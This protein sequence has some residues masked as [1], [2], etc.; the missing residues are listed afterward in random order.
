[1]SGEEQAMWRYCQW[2]A[3]ALTATSGRGTLSAEGLPDGMRYQPHTR[4][5]ISIP[6][7]SRS[8]AQRYRHDGPKICVLLGGSGTSKSDGGGIEPTAYANRLYPDPSSWIRI[9]DAIAHELPTARFY[10]I[11]ARGTVGKIPRTGGYSDAAIAEIAASHPNIVDCYDIGLWNDLALLASCDVFISPTSGFSWL[12]PCV[13]TP[14][15]TIAG[16]DW[17]DHFFNDVPFYSVL[18]D[19]PDYP[20]A[21]A[22]H[23]DENITKIPCMR[24]ENLAKKVPEIVEATRLL[25]RADFT[26]ADAVARHNE[27]IARA[28]VRREHIPTPGSPDLAFF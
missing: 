22:L 27:N 11:G 1:L 3:T 10:L 12:A 5:T 6:V 8:F 28:N 15:L 7:Q 24:P 18:P 25:L 16:G 2:A 17:H 4:V 14:A 23:F 26:Y 13:G 20:Y 19:N 9:L 21:G